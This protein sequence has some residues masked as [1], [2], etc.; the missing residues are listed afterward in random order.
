MSFSYFSLAPAIHSALETLEF[1]KPTDIQSQT[2]P[3]ALTGKDIIA[4]AQTGTGKTAAF[5]LP[6][7]NNLLR[8]DIQLGQVR[9]LVLAPTREL[10]Q[11][12]AEN[13]QQ[14]AA[15]TELTDEY[16]GAILQYPN[17]E[18]NAVNHKEFCEMAA[19]YDARVAVALVV[20]SPL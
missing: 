10:A 20:L 16:F 7:L 4:T 13:T 9:A 6:I 2:I 12:V 19:K 11:Q 5:M 3:L 1:E 14:Y 8:D 15:N 18:G 17:N